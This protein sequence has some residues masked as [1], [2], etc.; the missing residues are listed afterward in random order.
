[1]KGLVRI[2]P[3]ERT[4]L[5]DVHADLAKII[6]QMPEDFVPLT[7]EGSNEHPKAIDFTNIIGTG[8]LNFYISY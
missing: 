3:E 1:M 5:D 6:E 8:F 7:I 4:N 2:A